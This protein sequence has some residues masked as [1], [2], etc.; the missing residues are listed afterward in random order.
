MLLYCFSLPWQRASISAQRS[1]M[2]RSVRI[3]WLDHSEAYARSSSS[4]LATVVHDRELGLRSE[5]DAEL[6]FH[7]LRAPRI[8]EDV[9]NVRI[10]ELSLHRDRVA[11]HARVRSWVSVFDFICLRKFCAVAL[12]LS[13]SLS[14]SLSLSFSLSLSLSRSLSVIYLFSISRSLLSWSAISHTLGSMAQGLTTA[15]EEHQTQFRF[16]KEELANAA[17]DYK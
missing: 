1:Q 3:T 5:L 6:R 7:R 11:R 13:F 10:T 17:A 8:E 9:A 16:V 15:L 12:S 14:L 4:V 2:V